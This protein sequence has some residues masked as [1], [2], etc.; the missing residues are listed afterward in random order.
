MSQNRAAKTGGV[1][2]TPVAPTEEST[3]TSNT[4]ETSG[5]VQPLPEPTGSTDVFTSDELREVAAS[6][7]DLSDASKP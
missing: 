7:D 5:S 3:N 1:I 4:T 6:G 2:G